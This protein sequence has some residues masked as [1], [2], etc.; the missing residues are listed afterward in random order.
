MPILYFLSVVL[1]SSVALQA[2]SLL[3]EIRGNGL[4]ESAWIYG[5][6]HVRDSR[7]FQLPEGWQ[8]KL[9]Q[10]KR[11]ILELNPTETPDP[12]RMMDL[13]SAPK[14]STLEVL[15]KPEEKEL[16]EKWTSDSLHLPWT[17]VNQLKPFFLMAMIQER[18]M[19]KDMPQALDLWLAERAQE[20]KVPVLGLESLEKQMAAINSLSLQAQSN[21]LVE[22]LQ[23]NTQESEEE[24]EGLM[25]A[26]LKGNLNE[27]AALANQW[28]TDPLF[29]KEIIDS[30][31]DKMSDRISLTLQD[32][33][34]A[35]IAVGALHLPGP[36]GIIQQLRTKG[37]TVDPR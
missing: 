12:S 37:Y 21:M 36:T 28:E 7:V 20:W 26:Y 3:W 4:K 8:E 33:G 15:L 35:F 5:T 30:R 16:V 9:I 32:S 24:E 27:L 19:S 17:M 25:Q 18:Q 14:D 13:M 34:S 29:K 22:L 1:A 23:T 11:L 10:S 31:N 6:M 2:Q